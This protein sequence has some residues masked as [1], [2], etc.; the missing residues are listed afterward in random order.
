MLIVHLT[1]YTVEPWKWFPL[2]RQRRC[3]IGR[4][5]L[6]RCTSDWVGGVTPEVGVAHEATAGDVGVGC[7]AV[8]EMSLQL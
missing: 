7:R 3:Y 8:D 2:Y 4:R 5:K 6:A 1:L